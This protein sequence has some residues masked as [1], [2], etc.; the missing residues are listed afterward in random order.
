MSTTDDGKKAIAN[1]VL[2]STSK[3]EGAA[4]SSGG[5]SGSLE[6][7]TTEIV[8]ERWNELHVY[9]FSINKAGAHG[10]CTNT[11]YKPKGVSKSRHNLNIAPQAISISTPFA[12][13]AMAT[14]KGV[15][16]E[17]NG[18]VFR[19]I[20]I[21]GTTG[22]YP[23][24][25]S[26][27][28]ASSQVSGSFKSFAPKTAGAIDTLLNKVATSG[29]SSPSKSSNIQLEQTGY[30]QFWELNN[31]LVSYA[32]SKKSK[33]GKNFRLVFNCPKDNLSYVVTPMA[34][35]LSRSANDP[36]MYNY[37]IS[38]KAWDITTS[39]GTLD[40]NLTGIPSKDNIGAVNKVLDKLRKSRNV[41]QAASNVLKSVQGDIGS[42]LNIYNQGVLRIK[43]ITGGA[44]DIKDM[45]DIIRN[46]AQNMF[47]NNKIPWSEI[48]DDK[49]A[50]KKLSNLT[51]PFRT[52][53][54]GKASSKGSRLTQDINSGMAPGSV[55]ALN[56]AGS[57]TNADGSTP[58]AINEDVSAEAIQVIY[59]IIDDP[60]LSEGITLS[61]LGKF[62]KSMEAQIEKRIADSL[63]LTP[64]DIRRQADKL[65]EVSDNLAYKSGIMH[66]AYAKAYNIR[67]PTEEESKDPSEQDILLGVAIEEARDAYLTTLASGDM[68]DED[69]VNPFE[70]ANKNLEDK[71]ST[72]ISAYP[73]PVNR[74]STVEDIAIQFLGD[75]TR[76]REI[77]MLND[78]KTPYIDED[79]FDQKIKNCTGRTFVVNNTEKLAIRQSIRIMG[80]LMPTSRRSIINIEDIGAG[81]FRIT[82]DGSPD[83]NQYSA[84]KYPKLFAR[85]PG[86]VGSGDILLMPSDSP[87]DE[88]SV[89]KSTP[90]TE[91]LSYAEKV[92]KVDCAL[93]PVTSDLVVSSSGDIARSYGY[94]NAIQ[95]IR[96]IIETERQELF[97]HPEF[98]INLSIG[99]AI[100]TEV[101]KEITERIR[102]AIVKD[103]RFSNA[104]VDVRKEGTSVIIKVEVVGNNGT[105]RI[106]LE[107]EMPV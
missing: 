88:Q 45:P 54:A 40:K 43:D 70:S 77:V 65:K 82:V 104:I 39:A 89:L 69:D 75:A 47:K 85:I 24:R 49:I 31:F 12:I 107:F 76:S 36:L 30:Y 18:V 94:Q 44:K 60:E 17:N 16:E 93:D 97:L 7:K 98:G 86:T 10:E 96:L 28:K 9:S 37:S 102:G 68:Y 101:Y 29:K 55:S 74:G 103:P 3:V 38:L 79:G 14:N 13:S 73:V 35:N 32:E 6:R 56:G 23:L 81:E 25:E 19:S 8:G 71:I 95:A 78:L 84:D 87:A 72:P 48:T 58:S 61:R 1:K 67:I 22:L 4:G 11:E 64:G 99:K 21:S 63:R 91:R 34:F 66:P 2:K 41:M 62:S 105:G 92:F 33:D 27:A 46:N 52:E 83:L 26:A 57:H 53:S 15:L 100:T 90:L 51:N 20:N 50:S 59:K 80:V 106:P 42:V 5:G